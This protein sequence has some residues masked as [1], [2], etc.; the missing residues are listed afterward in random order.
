MLQHQ[1][2]TQLPLLGALLL[3]LL[4]GVSLLAWRW[5]AQSESSDAVVRHTV[6]TPAEDVLKYWTAERMRKTKATRMPHIGTP[7]RK[8]PHPRP[9]PRTPDQQKP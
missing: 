6:D 7:E 9:S 5:F 4:V 3:C 1:G 2:S 8:K